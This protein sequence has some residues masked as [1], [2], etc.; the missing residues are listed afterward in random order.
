M[1]LAPYCNYK[2][3]WYRGCDFTVVVLH[4]IILV[5]DIVLTDRMYVHADYNC[6]PFFDT[7]IVHIMAFISYDL[8]LILKRTNG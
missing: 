4:L 7:I 1:T 3:T 8:K 2:L 5:V 6:H